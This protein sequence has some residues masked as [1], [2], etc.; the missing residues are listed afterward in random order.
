VTIRVIPLGR[1]LGW[2]ERALEAMGLRKTEIPE[3]VL[4]L[5]AGFSTNL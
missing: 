5:I 2:R 1:S 4:G 3:P